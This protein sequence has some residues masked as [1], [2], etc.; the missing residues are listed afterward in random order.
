[1]EPPGLHLHFWH[2]ST[3]LITHT[4]FIGDFDAYSYKTREKITL[5][6][7]AKNS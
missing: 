5:Y 6:E 4:A 2:E 7:S 3:G 1:M